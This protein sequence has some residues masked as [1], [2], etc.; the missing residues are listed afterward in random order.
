VART[1]LL[2]VL[3]VSSAL[4][5]AASTAASGRTVVHYFHPFSNGRIASRVHV[6]ERGGGHCWE[7]SGVESR[8][9][10]WRCLR[11]SLI[12]DPC[13]SWTRHGRFVLCPVEPWSSD[14]VRLRLT[15][16]LPAWSL[17]RNA[18]QLPVGI[19][20]TTGKRCSHSS[21]ATSAV[22]GKEITYECTG[23]G[24]LVGMANAG[25]GTWTIWYA[26]G[27]QAHHL[28]RVGITDAWW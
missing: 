23:G 10:A 27:F 22:R 16:A 9:Y 7:P 11:G 26:P 6:M 17:H 4:V 25:V 13:F 8:R 3:L 12:L 28:T 24:V 19:W 1:A 5:A 15:R 20:T 14:V 18:A 2:A 21:G